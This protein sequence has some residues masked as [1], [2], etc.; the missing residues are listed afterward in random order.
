MSFLSD[1]EAFQERALQNASESVNKVVGELF[2]SVVALSPSPTN[3]GNYALGELSNQWYTASGT[4]PSAEVGTAISDNGADSLARISSTVEEHL[5]YGR[6][7][8]VSLSNNT[9]QAIYAELLGW[10]PGKGTGNWI[11]RGVPAYHMVSKSL[12]I[13]LNNNT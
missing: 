2:T 6:D 3:K 5:F 8:Q 9:E 4:T 12:N 10:L 7:N 13:V 1:I 11:W